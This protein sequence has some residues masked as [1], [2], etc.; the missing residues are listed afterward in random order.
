[1]SR[2]LPAE[3]LPYP[4]PPWKH[5]FRTLSVFCE[6]EELRLRS[7][8][9]SPLELRSTTLQITVM[10]FA[11]TVPKRH[12]FDSAV[13]APVRFEG[14]DGGY[15]IFGYTSTDQVLSG[16]REIWGFKMKLAEMEM[17]EL[18]NRITGSTH[19]LGKRIA[20]LTLTPSNHRFEPPDTFPRL[21][22]KVVP[23]ADHA[24]AA[25]KQ[26][27]KMAAE[28]EIEETIMGDGA[29]SFEASDEDPLSQLEPVNVVGASLVTGR[30]TLVWGEVLVDLD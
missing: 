21:F 25:V 1:M 9:P 5:A 26:I 18:P 12:Y 30:Q 11:C 3:H 27:V 15:W 16:T 17:N 4:L 22:Y 14:I 23:R 28:T 19:R 29:V 24:E 8:I 10:H 2:G 7:L 13:I 20:D 6:V